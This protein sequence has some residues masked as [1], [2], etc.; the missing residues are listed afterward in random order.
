VVAI[1]AILA[2]M[3]L[4]S[5]TGAQEASRATVCL[6]N[7]HQ[8][9][10]ASSNYS[11]DQ[12]GLYPSFLNW[13]DVTPG[14]LTTGRLFPYLGKNK[15]VYLCPTDAIQIATRTVPNQEP[16]QQAPFGSANYPR[17]YSYAMNCGI[18]HVSDVAAMPSPAKTLLFMEAELATNDYSGEVGPAVETHALA[19]RHNGRGHNLQADLH[20]E[21]LNAAA[22]TQLEKSK[23]FWFPTSDMRGPNGMN[24]NLN[25]PDP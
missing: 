19:V 8:F 6:N 17:N 21:T 10:L 14:D 9:A 5:L 4:P 24:F 12:K 20:V 23:T 25:L 2:A 15:L 3:L 18:C 13:L 22:S 11:M 7:L 16:S 1:I